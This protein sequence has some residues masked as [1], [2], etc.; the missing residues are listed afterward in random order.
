M[1]NSEIPE[2]LQNKPPLSG[3]ESAPPVMT[4]GDHRSSLQK[5]MASIVGDY[6]EHD[7]GGFTSYTR[8]SSG[9][10]PASARPSSVSLDDIDRQQQTFTDRYTDFDHHVDH[11]NTFSGNSIP[12]ADNS[13]SINSSL[14]TQQQTQNF[15]NSTS[16]SSDFD[17][18][19]LAEKSVIDIHDYSV[20]NTQAKAWGY[21]RHRPYSRF[22]QTSANSSSTQDLDHDSTPTAFHSDL[23][24]TLV[25]S[26]PHNSSHIRSQSVP[27]SISNQIVPTNHSQTNQI[28]SNHSPTNQI[29]S[30]TLTNIDLSPIH[31]HAM[32]TTPNSGKMNTSQQQNS[33]QKYN[34]NRN[35]YNF[36]KQNNI[37]P[38]NSRPII[39]DLDYPENNVT[40]V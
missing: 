24:N 32:N 26:S 19:C 28:H 20:N 14:P 1:Q 25:T 23:D 9:V 12:H 8:S 30:H 15:F 39:V 27:P 35:G 31:P 37:S 22:L 34:V 5:Y 17:D 6:V 40:F 11:S 18:P 29:H 33:V 36:P 4:G 7:T 13:S 3:R 2:F 10:R 21:S 16:E 38:N